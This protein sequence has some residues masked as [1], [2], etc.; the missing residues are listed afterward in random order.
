MTYALNDPTKVLNIDVNSISFPIIF[1]RPVLAN[2]D[3]KI[4]VLAGLMAQKTV[5]LKDPGFT[6]LIVGE[7][8]IRSIERDQ[9][10]IT[11]SD[12]TI[13]YLSNKKLEDKIKENAVVIINS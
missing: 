1:I 11:K 2:L 10:E 12:N 7:Y 3:M 6:P 5:K 4:K 8:P 13:C 9:F